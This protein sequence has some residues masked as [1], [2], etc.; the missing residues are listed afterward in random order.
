MIRIVKF[1]TR[2][3]LHKDPVDWV[4]VAPMGESF[5][6]VQTWHRVSK[7]NP[8]NFPPQ[9]QE[10]EGFNDAV[11]KWKVI[12]PAY[13]AWKAGNSLP[14]SGTPLEAWSGVTPEQVKLLKS[15][16]VRT[17]EDVRDMGDNTMTKLRIPNVRQL[18][19]LADEYLSG[20]DSSEK[21]A[22]IAD[23]EERLAAMA[24]VMEE[25][26]APKPK[27]PAPK[28]KSEEAA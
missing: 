21:D 4:L 22:R 20:A 8:E 15:F 9:R 17:V 13:E 11:M 12:G 2:Y 5:D 24:E 3:P 26:T 28:P 10:G 25:M 16:D 6:K 7:I 14:E 27:K 19:K 23:L 18:P 1:E